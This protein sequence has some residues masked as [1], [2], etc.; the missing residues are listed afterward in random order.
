MC[1]DICNLLGLSQCSMYLTINS[2][3]CILNS[4]LLTAVRTEGS[5]LDQSPGQTSITKLRM[6]LRA[7]A[8]TLQRRLH[9]P[10]R[11]GSGVCILLQP[12]SSHRPLKANL[13][14]KENNSTS[15]DLIYRPNTI[16]N[17]VLTNAEDIAWRDRFLETV[18]PDIEA[19]REARRFSLSIKIVEIKF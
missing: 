5:N 1:R 18:H 11:P 13:S 14:R 2:N 9:L 8:K 15:I 17:P 10:G 19:A 4:S 16:E 7:D 6:T 3:K 12:P